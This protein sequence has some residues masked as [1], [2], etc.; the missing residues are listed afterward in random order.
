MEKIKELLNKKYVFPGAL[1]GVLMLGAVVA[2][3]SQ[4]AS[5]IIVIGGWGALISAKKFIK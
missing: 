1:F 3:W 4:A 2:S 5:G